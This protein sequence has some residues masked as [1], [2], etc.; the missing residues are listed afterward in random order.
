MNT[1]TTDLCSILQIASFNFFISFLDS[2]IWRR[3]RRISEQQILNR[4]SNLEQLHFDLNFSNN[5]LQDLY[6]IYFS[7]LLTLTK[8]IFTLRSL[9]L[10]RIRNHRNHT[11]NS[12]TSHR[13]S[14]LVPSQDDLRPFDKNVNSRLPKNQKLK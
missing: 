5:F 6:R 13:R 10:I 7:R 14:T 4:I 9:F 8:K 12:Q 11:S 1:D 2:H 3:S